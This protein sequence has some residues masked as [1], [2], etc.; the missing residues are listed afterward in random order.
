MM[1]TFCQHNKMHKLVLDNASTNCKAA[2]ADRI[3]AKSNK[4]LLWILVAIDKTST[5]P[6]STPYKF[7]LPPKNKHSKGPTVKK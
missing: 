3:R 5:H 6:R 2:S 1:F 4:S 7:S